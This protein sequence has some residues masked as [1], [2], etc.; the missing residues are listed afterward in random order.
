[1]RRELG[2]AISVMLLCAAVAF[3]QPRREIAFPDIPGYQTLKCDFH[4]HTVFSDGSVWPSVRVDE[5]W[6]EG[7]DAIA[8][9]DHIEYQPHKSDVP[10]N[11][12][13]PYDLAAS[14]ALQKGIILIRG[15]EITRDTPPGHYN[16]IFLRD[17]NALDKE[18][19]YASCAAG[20]EQGFV[21]WNH[22]GWQGEERGAWGEW[23]QK[24]FDRKHLHGIE[25]CNENDYYEYAHRLA[26]KHG[27]TLIGN[28]DIHGPSL[29]L[30]DSPDKHRLLTLVFA[31]ERSVQGVRDALFAG[32]TAI[33]FRNSLI[34]HT[35]EL[36]PLFDACV[37]VHPPH[38]SDDKRV[39]LRVENRSE[40]DIQ[41]ERTGEVGPRKLTLPARGT[42]L[43]RIDGKP[44]DVAAG[45]FYR[46]T[47]ILTAPGQGLEVQLRPTAPPVVTLRN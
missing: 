9:T 16:A 46:A 12:N 47:N 45:L 32:R 33:W 15:A 17:V 39:W 4:M 26:L 20:A 21:F 35:R 43:L 19:F 10:T 6:R 8:L 22:P 42:T 44:A 31:A 36:R 37:H 38:H 18:D 34:G 14:A 5:A 23:Q 1:M 41:L 2:A 7:L 29:G 11:H 30:G 25:V 40:L 24:L 13:R 3:G 28:S 27:L